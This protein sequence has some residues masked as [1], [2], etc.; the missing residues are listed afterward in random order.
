MFPLPVP[1]FVPASSPP[2]A[3][4]CSTPLPSLC[5]LS[6]LEFCLPFR[7]LALLPSRLL[8]SLPPFLPSL[9]LS[10]YDGGARSGKVYNASPDLSLL[11][12]FL[13]ASRCSYCWSAR[14]AVS[15]SR[16]FGLLFLHLRLFSRGFPPQLSVADSSASVF[17]SSGCPPC[18]LP[19]FLFFHC[20]LPP[21]ASASPP[22]TF[23]LDFLSLCLLLLSNLFFS[24]FLA[25]SFF[26]FFFP[27]PCS[28]LL[29]CVFAPPPFLFPSSLFT[30]F[31]FLSLF[32]FAPLFTVSRSQFSHYSFWFT[33]LS[34]LPLTQA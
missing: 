12:F 29:L 5:S 27:V 28:S 15:P 1:P 14:C 17:P 23:L 7:L 33:S 19:S 26:R 13:P 31:P 11:F 21:F 24:S 16:P 4:S 32:L 20:P 3:V 25:L 18:S 22:L 9:F 8:F 10:L 30:L 34:L 6:S 2:V